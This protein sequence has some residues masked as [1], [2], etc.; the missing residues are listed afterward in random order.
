MIKENLQ[1]SLNPTSRTLSNASR[2]EGGRFVPASSRL[3][4]IIE[5]PKNLIFWNLIVN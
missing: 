3:T 2:A 1:L 4:K 5:K